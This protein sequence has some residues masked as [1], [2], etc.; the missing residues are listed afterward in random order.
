[1]PPKLKLFFRMAKM[2][3]SHVRKDDRGKIVEKCK[4]LSEQ[5][6]VK[7]VEL[8]RKRQMLWAN[9]DFVFVVR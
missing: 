4:E 9:N 7:A 6:R 3:I 8:I 5:Q 2:E 1:M